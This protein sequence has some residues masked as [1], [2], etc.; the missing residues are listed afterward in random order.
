R[1]GIF[2]ITMPPPYDK[3][4]YSKK[5]PEGAYKFAVGE[6]SAYKT[7]QVIGGMPVKDIE[8]IDIGI[9][10]V[11]IGRKGKELEIHFKRDEEDAYKGEDIKEKVQTYKLPSSG[12]KYH[13]NEMGKLI[14]DQEPKS[15][16]GK[17]APKAIPVEKLQPRKPEA[18]EPVRREEPEKESALVG[19]R[20]YF[21]HKLPEPSLRSDL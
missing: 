19:D 2:W 17:L 15:R 10:I 12:L 16:T 18:S 8:G 20:Y 14:I 6:D 21:G 11:D 4:Y 9:A 1:Q 13:T 7:I 3:R 5:S